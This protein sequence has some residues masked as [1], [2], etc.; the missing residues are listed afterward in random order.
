MSGC[1]GTSCSSDEG[2]P[3]HQKANRRR[4]RQ[5]LI[6]SRIDIPWADYAYAILNEV[7]DG[8]K[9]IDLVYTVGRDTKVISEKTF[10]D[11][12]KAVANLIERHRLENPPPR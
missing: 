1:G 5:R 11:M 7:S 10:D 4:H 6:E 8:T 2:R 3:T 9:K 12:R